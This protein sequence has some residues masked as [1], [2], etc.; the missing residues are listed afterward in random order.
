MKDSGQNAREWE[1]ANPRRAIEL[2][3]MLDAC[4]TIDEKRALYKTFTKEEQNGLIPE[5]CRRRENK[6]APVGSL[7]KPAH[8][9]RGISIVAGRGTKHS[10]HATH[11]GLATV[12]G[13]DGYGGMWRYL[14]LH[15]PWRDREGR[16]IMFAEAPSR[17]LE[18]VK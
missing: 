3:D 7:V 16:C 10:I 14:V 4:T 1:E 2:N 5:F 13:Q 18:V 8:E 11:F 15:P 6:E 12:I 17:D 9:V